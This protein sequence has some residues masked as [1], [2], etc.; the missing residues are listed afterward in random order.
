VCEPAT[1]CESRITRIPTGENFVCSEWP[2]LGGG[3]ALPC[4]ISVPLFMRHIGAGGGDPGNTRVAS[5]EC[6][7]CSRRQAPDS[8]V[9]SL[10]A[11]FVP[12]G[13]NLRRDGQGALPSEPI[14]TLRAMRIT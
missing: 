14:E 8:K 1:N 5:R 4:Q 12:A 11:Y 6:A 2:V 3:A 9:Q 13:R 10:S 7:L